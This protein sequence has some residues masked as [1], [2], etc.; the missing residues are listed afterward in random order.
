MGCYDL[1]NVKRSVRPRFC[2]VS[3]KELQ[4]N[5]LLGSSKININLR[6]LLLIVAEL[7]INLVTETNFVNAVA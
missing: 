5:Y 4:A 6:G 7:Q 1:L 2:I 3:L